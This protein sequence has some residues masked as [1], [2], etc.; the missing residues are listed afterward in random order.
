LP[1]KN[2]FKVGIDKHFCLTCGGNTHFL[3]GKGVCEKY[4]IDQDYISINDRLS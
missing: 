3:C 4:L 1:S 2:Y